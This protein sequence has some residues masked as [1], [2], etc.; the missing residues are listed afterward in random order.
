MIGSFIQPVIQ[1]SSTIV[2][3]GKSLPPLPK[4][5]KKKTE[6]FA[7]N[8]SI[9]GHRSSLEHIT[10]GDKEFYED[11]RNGVDKSSKMYEIKKEIEGNFFMTKCLHFNM[12]G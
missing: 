8:S 3:K 2:G 6:E 9:E 11:G 12:Y 5:R 10:E 7:S 4:I 1:T